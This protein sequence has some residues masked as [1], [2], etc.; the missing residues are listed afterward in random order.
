[1]RVM[2]VREGL[3][4]IRSSHG[5]RWLWWTARQ[6][7]YSR[8]VSIGV[9]RDMSVSFTVPPPKIPLVVRQLR[10]DDDRSFI[11]DVPGLAPQ[12]A[13]E[14]AVQRW[15]LSADLP[16]CWV[17]VDPDGT[18]CS[19]TW[20]ITARD[21]ALVRAWWKGLLPELQPDEALFESPTRRRAIAGGVSC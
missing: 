17:A 2:Q 1:M 10:P 11:A 6:R 15:L 9:R 14:H 18:V 19:M 20:L 8:R 13:Q 4:L 7:L 3:E 16:A 5:R 12:E 21:N